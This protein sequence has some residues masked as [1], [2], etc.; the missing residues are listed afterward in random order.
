MVS[1]S[2]T[3]NHKQ[4]FLLAGPVE[5]DVDDDDEK[6]LLGSAEIVVCSELP[7]LVSRCLGAGPSP[8][9]FIAT[10]AL[11]GVV[12]LHILSLTSL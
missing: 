10:S 3:L 2:S 5:E 12:V 8:S 1:I 7:G 11:S 4:V 9:C 6:S